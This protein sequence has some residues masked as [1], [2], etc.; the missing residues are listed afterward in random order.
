[1]CSTSGAACGMREAACGRQSPKGEATNQLIC[2][3]LSLLSWRTTHASRRHWLGQHL[4]PS[5]LNYLSSGMPPPL[6]LLPLPLPHLEPQLLLAACWLNEKK[7]R[8]YEILVGFC[9]RRCRCLRVTPSP[10]PPCPAFP[11]V[12]VPPFSL[13]LLSVCVY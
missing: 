9:R 3:L 11:F 10:T 7:N 2:S 1:M 6:G 4:L 13:Y 5:F 12:Y 8:N